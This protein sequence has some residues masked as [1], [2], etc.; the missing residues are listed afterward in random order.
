MKTLSLVVIL[1]SITIVFNAQT[2][3]LEVSSG[4]NKN[5][6][7]VRPIDA[8]LSTS[9][10]EIK[11]ASASVWTRMTYEG[12]GINTGYWTYN[13]W[14]KVAGFDL[15]LSFRLTSA[16]GAVV[17]LANNVSTFPSIAVQYDTLTQYGPI[18]EPTISIPIGETLKLEVSDGS[19][20][21]WMAVRDNAAAVSTRSIEIKQAS[22][23]S[24]VPMTFE[25]T[26]INAGYWTYKDWSKVAGFDMPLSFRLTGSNGVQVILTGV[27]SAF[28]GVVQIVDS[29]SQYTSSIP[30]ISPTSASTVNPT[31]SATAKPTT[32]PTT[33]PVTTT[34]PQPGAT[35]AP[36][37]RPTVAATTKSTTSATVKP[38]TAATTRPTTSATVK[39]TTAATIRP[40]TAA[41]ARPTTAATARPT[42]AATSRPT[43]AP[44]IPS[45]G[46][47]SA[48]TKMLVPLYVY[49]GAAWDKVIEGARSVKTVAIIN[50][51]S[52]PGGA[53]DS[54][55]QTYMQ[56]LHD[57]GVDM[58]GYVYTSYGA[59]AQSAV[60]ADVDAYAS[61][62][63]LVKG[64]FL[65]EGANSAS[66]LSFYKDL[67]TYI[68]SMPGYEYNIINPGVIPDSGYLTAATQIV[69][70]EDYSSSVSSAG[71]PS[72]ASC[73]NKEKFSAIV[74]TASASS[75]QSV[76]NN[77]LSKGY[78]GYVYVTDGAGGCCTYNQLA[79][80]YTS[81]ASYIGA[82]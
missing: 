61:H 54:T 27:I 14:S 28:P 43:T 26:G 5:W 47:C 72:Y 51:S 48:K 38:T 64:I 52:G 10:I 62:F 79:S 68:M 3:K 8:T 37:V 31:I 15:P 59:R 7:A 66:Q 71:I 73:Q 34:T 2:L 80:Y 65:D 23:T 4:S 63:P 36:T 82:R 40:T 33:K 44:T 55:Y 77:I 53:P 6:I 45:S 41:T 60:K 11:Q 69:T 58:V 81:M 76:I 35:T 21:N 70:L 75:M 22:F 32:S 13:D 39:P 9:I 50:P 17:T 16:N 49:P 30:T 46:G 20:K 19:N 18:V 67:H 57:A 24:W 12:T 1:L 78:F 25:A 74:H 56:K 29:H 42:T